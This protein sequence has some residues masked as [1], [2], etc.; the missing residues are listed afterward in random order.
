MV[1]LDV[2]I[3]GIYICKITDRNLKIYKFTD[4]FIY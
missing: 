2:Y 1:G 4:L 3:K